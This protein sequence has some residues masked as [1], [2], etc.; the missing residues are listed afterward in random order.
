MAS[1]AFG[2]RPD[3]PDIMKRRPLPV[4]MAFGRR[5]L[6][7]F[8]EEAAVDHI[9]IGIDVGKSFCHVC[10][11]NDEADCVY[12]DAL[13]TLDMPAWRELLGLFEGCALHAVFE[14]G[15]HYDWMYDLLMEH[16]T[17]V[18]VVA[19][20][21]KALK[22]TDRLDAAK[23]ARDLWRG[24]LESIFI[25]PKAMRKDR[26]L[27]AR[28]HVLSSQIARIKINLRDM[29]YTARLT[30]THTDLGSLKAQAWLREVA[31]PQM[32]EQE[33]LLMEHLL[34]Q[35]EL[36]QKQYQTLYARVAGR[37]S[38]YPQARIARSIPGFGPLV[39]LSVLSAIGRVGRF[40]TP[41]RLASYFGLCGSI[42]Q[43]GDRLTIG[44]ITRSG[45][46]HVRWLIGQAVTHLIRSDPKSRRRYLK[47]R[48]KKKP[49]VA[50]VALMRWVTTVLWRMLNN[51]EQ[52]RINGVA[53][54][55]RKP[56]VA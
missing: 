31:L 52:Y 44:S 51:N 4:S 10:V 33:A 32:E 22:K 14:I 23:L 37:L 36:F 6:E 54:N 28:V 2:T 46:R 19:P 55:Y 40:E 41:D 15:G 49:K 21:R 48:R 7:P 11:L 34:E 47:L 43:S 45:N 56:R 27:I 24:D 16:C 42:D 53:G 38:D 30:C 13:S 29:L 12:V 3:G 20:N 18:I 25:P 5:S 17:E 35:F 9:Y 1:C 39:T 8:L 26:R 50:R